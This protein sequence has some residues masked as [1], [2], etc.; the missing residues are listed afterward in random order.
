[1]A[2]SYIRCALASLSACVAFGGAGSVAAQ[3]CSRDELQKMAD[4]YVEAQTKGQPN[5]LPLGGWVVYRENAKLAS[6]S[7]D[8][9]STPLKI[10]WHRSLLDTSQCK[11]SLEMIVTDQ[12]HPYVIAVQFSV[13]G[14]AA[15]NINVI[16][17]EEHDWLFDAAKT[18][19]YARREDWLPIPV[20]RQDTVPTLKAVADA[21]LDLFK[22]KTVEVPWGTPCA[23]LEGSVYTARGKPDDSCNV[24]VPENVEMANR[25]YVFDQELGAVDVFLRMGAK[26][27]P[28]SHRFRIEG[29]KIRYIHTITNCGD[30]ENCG[31]GSFKEILAKNPDMQPDPALFD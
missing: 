1:M 29:G 5:I 19:E 2:N 4:A 10:D 20:G 21:Y 25:E 31:F 15:N 16:I 3:D 18:F 27:R 26:K 6:M 11:I 28:D 12:A 9:L 22:D 23:R 13:R 8:L 24:G 30:E 17:S 14:G 7:T